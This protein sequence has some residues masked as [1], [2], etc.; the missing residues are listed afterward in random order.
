MNNETLQP[1]WLLGSCFSAPCSKDSD[2][3][4]CLNAMTR[5]EHEYTMQ[6]NQTDGTFGMIAQCVLGCVANWELGV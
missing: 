2:E 5:D 3:F 1:L 4:C 6:C